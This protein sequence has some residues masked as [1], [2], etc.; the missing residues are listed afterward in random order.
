MTK[1]HTMTR[2]QYMAAA[3]AAGVA[4][5]FMPALGTCAPSWNFL[6][7]NE[8]NGLT[9]LSV[10]GGSALS[11][12]FVFW[13]KNWAWAGL[14][15]QFKVTA[16]YQY[17]I[18]GISSALNF[19][20]NGRVQKTSSRQ[21]RWTI[22][23]DASHRTPDVIGGGISFR[24]NLADFRNQ[25]GDPELLPGNR[26]W[27]WGRP[28][29]TRIELR[30]DPALPRVYFEPLSGKSEIRAM[31]YNGEVP[32]GQRH[33]TATLALSGDIEIVPTV[34]E[35]FG[36]KDASAWPADVVDWQASPVD[37]SFLNAAE[38]PAGK[39]G[40]LTAAHGRLVF[41]DG[42]AARFWGTNLVAYALFATP[43]EAVKHQAHRLAELG[44]NL[45]R[46]HHFDSTWVEPNIFGAGAAL[47]TKHLDNASLEKLD[48]WIECLKDEGIYIWL[49]LEDGRQFKSADGIDDFAEIA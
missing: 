16:P 31:F 36:L 43:R 35:K 13:A 23:L 1:P 45:V 39:R 11:S 17:S 24:F 47:D 41:A 7:I 10:G 3:G 38:K 48:W 18:T 30:F 21:L 9:A 33:Y 29:A 12:D 2:R 46:I 22:D 27:S 8:T 5:V 20:L 25:F 14:D 34:T 26:G 42:T 28:D 6:S 37:L 32:P 4:S 49:D 15:T 44:F 40:F 19:R